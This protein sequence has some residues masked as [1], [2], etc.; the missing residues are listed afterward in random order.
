MALLHV[1]LKPSHSN[2]EPEVHANGDVEKQLNS[3]ESWRIGYFETI[4]DSCDN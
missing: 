2:S 3:D 1:L 4:N